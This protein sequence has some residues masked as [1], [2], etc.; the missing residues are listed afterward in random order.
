[1]SAHA[2][3]KGLIVDENEHPVDVAYVG[4]EPMYVINDAG[5]L[6]H[7]PSKEIDLQILR[8]LGS[9]IKGNEELIAD[10]TSKMIGEV[11]LFTHAFIENQLKNIDKQYEALIETG[12]PEETIA[13]LGMIG[14]KAV[15]NFHGDIV[16]IEQPAAAASG[17]EGEGE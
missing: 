1:M 10:E 2:L 3:F 11:D 8:E 12:I 13:Y 5:F 4:G 15:I 6:R 16:R 9:Q 17:D 14:L 7:I